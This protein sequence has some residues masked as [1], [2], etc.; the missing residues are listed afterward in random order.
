MQKRLRNP[1]SRPPGTD[2]QHPC[3]STGDAEVLLQIAHQT[4]PVGVVPDDLIV[5]RKRQRIDRVCDPGALGNLIGESK[6]R[7]LEGQRDVQPCH[8]AGLKVSNTL[9]KSDGVKRNRLVG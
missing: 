2:N 7:L 5:P 1:S 6:G 9:F 3:V 4:H 8:T